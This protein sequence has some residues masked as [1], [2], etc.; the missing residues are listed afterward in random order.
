MVI[1][2][3]GFRDEELLEP[4]EVL[5]KNNIEVRIASTDLTLAKGK[6][7]KTVKPDMLL[8]DVNAVDFDAVIFIG[9]PGCIIYWGDSLAHKLLKEAVSS[10][11]IVAGICSAAATLAKAGI[12]KQKR[13]T[14]FPGDSKE[15]IDNQAIYTAHSVERD[16]NIITASG[17]AA[18]YAFGEE[19]AKA[20][21][22]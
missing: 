13:A 4:K 21:K 6:L 2:H 15:L 18:A 9:G 1:A 3:E 11:K 16:G 7:G 10:G 17:P 20:L 14:I 22:E 19:I 5:E 8:K 12:L